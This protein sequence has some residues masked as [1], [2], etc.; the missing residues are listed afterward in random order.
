MQF[1]G[2][3]DEG[4]RSPLERRLVKHRPLQ[5]ALLCIHEHLGIQP[6]RFRIGYWRNLLQAKEGLTKFQLDFGAVS[7]IGGYGDMH[8]AVADQPVRNFVR[9]GQMWLK[10]TE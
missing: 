3:Y 6:F 5:M 9:D 10:I 1:S 8:I 7:Q 2:F 4:A